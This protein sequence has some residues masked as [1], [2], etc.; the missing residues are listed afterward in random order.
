TLLPAEAVLA[1]LTSL[2]SIGLIAPGD[3]NLSA[4]WPVEQR[5]VVWDLNVEGRASLRLQGRASGHP[6]MDLPGALYRF[7]G[8]AGRRLY[9]GTTVE[10]DQR[11]PKHRS[12]SWW[13]EVEDVEVTWYP[14]LRAAWHAERVAIQREDPAYNVA[15]YQPIVSAA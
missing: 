7:L 5:P 6:A 8:P 10:L 4:G 3:Q 1:A 15:R 12:K 14:N 9:I 11:W 2:A 13:P